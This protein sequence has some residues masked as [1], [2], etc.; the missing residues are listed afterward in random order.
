MTFL[1]DSFTQLDGLAC[2]AGLWVAMKEGRRTHQGHEIHFGTNH[3]GHYLL[4]DLLRPMLAK[5]ARVVMVSSELMLQGQLD[6]EERS[7]VEHGRYGFPSVLKGTFYM[8]LFSFQ[9]C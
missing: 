2:N 7:F 3:L 8:F 5:D 6:M 9:A 4:V 1:V